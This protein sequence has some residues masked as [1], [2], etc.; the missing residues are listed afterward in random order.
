MLVK[1]TGIEQL[2]H[3]DHNTPA[4]SAFSTLIFLTTVAGCE[5]MMIGVIIDQMK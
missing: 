4:N 1:T 2:R 3:D 5:S